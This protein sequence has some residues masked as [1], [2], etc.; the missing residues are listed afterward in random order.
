MTREGTMP[1]IERAGCMLQIAKC[2]FELV[3]VF[4]LERRKLTLWTTLRNRSYVQ[5][6]GLGIGD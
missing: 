2:S 3:W 6:Q 5:R 1:V 4:H